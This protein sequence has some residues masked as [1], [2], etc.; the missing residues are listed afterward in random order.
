M[1][2][3]NL[4]L[5]ETLKINKKSNV[6]TSDIDLGKVVTDVSATW[7][8]KPELTLLWTN[9]IAFNDTAVDYNKDLTERLALGGDRPQITQTIK[10]L[11][12]TINEHLSYVKDMIT[13]KYK[14]KNATS[15]YPAFGIV[16]RNKRYAIPS[17]QNT[18]LASLKLMLSGL[19]AHGFEADEFGTAFWQ[20]IH[21]QYE[22]FVNNASTTDGNV[23]AKVS[24]KNTYKKELNKTLRALINL[25]KANYPDTY[26]AE[27]RTWGFQKE[28][29]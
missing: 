22:L 21:D 14:K 12:V 6:P 25:I 24:S 19:V 26:K 18:R 28:K 23:S 29:Y 1:S 7:L 3:T 4:P 10:D 5:E 20:P 15:Y 16:Y 8:T 17:D 27:L 9:Q 2:N 11:D 13:K